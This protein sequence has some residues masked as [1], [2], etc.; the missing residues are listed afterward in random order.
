MCTD[1]VEECSEM[2][3]LHMPRARLTASHQIPSTSPTLQPWSP[4][5]AAT[6]YRALGIT[7]LFIS[8][9]EGEKSLADDGR[10][11]I[12]AS[13]RQLINTEMSEQQLG[14]D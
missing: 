10:S 2:G 6:A 12:T 9:P 4:N 11:L 1:G 13:I 8:H 14:T 7:H 3:S 5:L